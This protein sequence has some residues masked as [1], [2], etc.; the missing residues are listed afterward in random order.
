[1]EVLKKKNAPGMHLHPGTEINQIISAVPPALNPFGFH[2][3]HV[4]C[5]LRTGLLS[6]SSQLLSRN[7]SKFI[8]TFEILG[9]TGRLPS[10]PL[11]SF[12]VRRSQ[13]VTPTSCQVLK[14]RVLFP[15]FA[16]MS[17]TTRP[18]P[19]RYGCLVFCR[20]PAFVTKCHAQCDDQCNALP[21]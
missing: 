13:S 3:L 10:V 7:V 9:S 6:K 19:N 4:T 1:M 14:T 2:S 21:Y 8:V 18:G 20:K 5:A 12:P 11:T 17:V 15:A 16:V